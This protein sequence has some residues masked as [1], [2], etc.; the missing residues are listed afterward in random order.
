MESH[1][2]PLTEVL[3]GDKGWLA[4]DDMPGRSNPHSGGGGN[5]CDRL[6]GG[7]LLIA[8]GFRG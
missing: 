5:F 3:C 7:D 4:M 2:P 1:G 6:V 8:S